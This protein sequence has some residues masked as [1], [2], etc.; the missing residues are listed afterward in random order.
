[1]KKAQS[2]KAVLPVPTNK[3]QAEE[4]DSYSALIVLLLG[5]PL[6]LLHSQYGISQHQRS[7]LDRVVKTASKIVSSALISTLGV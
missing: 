3:F 7:R 5:V 2:T 1:M 4:G 6:H